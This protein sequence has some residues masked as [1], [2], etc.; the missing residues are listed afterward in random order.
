MT[1]KR[2]L[3]LGFVAILGFGFCLKTYQETYSL[4]I[5]DHFPE[6]TFPKDNALTESRVA[7]GKKLFYDPILS[8][9][10]S[11]SCASCHQPAYA[12]TDGLKTSTGSKE[13]KTLRNAPTL[14]NV[15][16]QDSGLL[17]DG[18]VPTLEMQVIVPVQEHVE[19]DFDLRL[20]A[21]RLKKDADYVQLAMDAY[22]QTPN[23]FVITRAIAA[24]ERTLISGNSRFDQ[25]FL[26]NTLNT[27]SYKE[28]LG[29]SLFHDK[30]NCATCHSGFN[31]TNLSLQ[32]NGLYANKYPADS[33][34]MR[35]T[36]K[37]VDRD[38]FKVPTLRN[39]E[40]TAPYMHDG[41][42]AS[43]EEV[44]DH[45]ASGG[46]NHPNKSE[47]I[48]PFELSENE[49]QALIGFLKSLT[50]EEFLNNKKFLPEIGN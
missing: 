15:A 32:N 24:F 4:V 34:R 13:Q 17:F 23:P 3:I 14:T 2:G 9:D 29:Y 16:Y 43:L 30:L 18:G 11:I 27:L 48:K 26:G 35:I 10:R 38:K 25:Y 21:E 6:I 22:S 44:I 42:I 12:F 8:R 7:L 41:S 46:K 36:H 28:L 31:F 49:K 5:P 39:I 1:I 40:V 33:G 45:Y 20:I 19:F 37:E 47:L 50:D